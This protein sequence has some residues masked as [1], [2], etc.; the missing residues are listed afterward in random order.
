[1][2]V[3]RSTFIGPDYRLRG[4]MQGTLDTFG[5]VEILQILGRMR[6]SGTLH[7]ECPQRPHRRPLRRTGASP[8]RATPPGSPPTPSSAVSSSSGRWSTS[9]SSRPPWTSR[10]CGRGRSA[11]SSSTTARSRRA[12]CARC[13]RGRSPTRWWPPSS[14]PPGQFVFVV[15]ADPQ[16][17]DFITVDTAVGAA[18]HLGPR[19]RVLPRRRD[20]RPAVHGARAQRRLQHAAAQSAAHGPRRVRRAAAGGRL[21]DGQ[22]DHA[23][24]PPRGDHGGEHPRQ[25]G[26]R[27]RAA[28]QG[29]AAVAGR[30]RRRAAGAPR[31]RV[32]GGQPAARRHRRRARTPATGRRARSD[33]RSRRG[34]SERSTAAAT[35]RRKGRA[36]CMAARPFV[37]PSAGAARGGRP[38]VP[39][40][41]R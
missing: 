1:M 37:V 39:Q 34:S 17:V 8:R 29:G 4:S 12:P 38:S 14:R 19:R 3:C 16:P 41:R 15:D 30:G 25:A 22:G 32:G 10:R 2:C 33:G 40:L 21:A 35:G 24:E 13:S 5:V 7:I 31:Q 36:A 11:P 27:R 18:R 28:G 9:S 20:A 23:G 6:R 26:R